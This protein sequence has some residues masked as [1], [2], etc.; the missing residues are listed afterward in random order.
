MDQDFR[1]RRQTSETSCSTPPLVPIARLTAGARGSEDASSG[2]GV[3]TGNG[4]PGRS[5]TR[6]GDDRG[7]PSHCRRAPSIGG[8]QCGDAA[9]S[10]QGKPKR[11]GACAAE[12]LQVVAGRGA[13]EGELKLRD[14]VLD[15]LHVPMLEPGGF[16]GGHP[17]SFGLGADARRPLWCAG[18]DARSDQPV[19]EIRSAVLPGWAISHWP[20]LATFARR[21]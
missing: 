6:P 17:M 2:A 19:E 3:G 20:D 14:K 18:V 15:V 13:V 7:R 11:G 16:C 21:A 8:D 12:V 4:A 9:P 1:G 10:L 5:K